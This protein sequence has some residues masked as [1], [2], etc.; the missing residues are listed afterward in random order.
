MVVSG[1]Y[2]DLGQYV[3]ESVPEKYPA[4]FKYGHTFAKHVIA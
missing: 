1:K 3:Q 2:F 4:T